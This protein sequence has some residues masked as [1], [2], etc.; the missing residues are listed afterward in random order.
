MTREPTPGELAEDL[1]ELKVSMAALHRKIDDLPFVRLD[2]YEARHAALRTEVAL[3][4]ARVTKDIE[5]ARG[6]AASSRA[7]SMWALG[8]ICTAVV[9][10]IV[11]FLISAG[12]S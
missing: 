7:I 4:L 12:G 3:E 8:L 10:G 6:V 5:D 1:A 11:T 9:A 2:V